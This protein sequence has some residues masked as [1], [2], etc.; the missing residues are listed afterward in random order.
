MQV[1]LKLWSF[2]EGIRLS[3]VMNV[4]DFQL[5]LKRHSHFFVMA[6]RKYSEWIARKRCRCCTIVADRF[7]V[8]VVNRMWFAQKI[9]KLWT[10]DFWTCV[11][12]ILYSTVN[13]SIWVDWKQTVR[14]DQANEFQRIPYGSFRSNE[15]SPHTQ[16]RNHECMGD[17]WHKLLLNKPILQ[18]LWMALSN[19]C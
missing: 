4:T 19:C 18:Y 2:F 13:Y 7:P 3:V 5:R 10:W 17:R 14:K 8:A 1:G 15:N 6:W 9:A 12:I 16:T 11:G